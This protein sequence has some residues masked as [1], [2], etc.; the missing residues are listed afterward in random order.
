M[1][2]A[3]HDAYQAYLRD[4][5]NRLRLTDWVVELHRNTAEAGA[6]ASVNVMGTQD[7]AT[8]RLAWPEFFG[9]S[10][11]EQR[12]HLVHELVHCVLHR[13]CDVVEQLAEMWSE[14]AACQFARKAFLR[15]EEIAVEHLA[16]VI[17][18]FLPLP[19]SAGEPV[20]ARRDSGPQDAPDSS[21]GSDVPVPG[22]PSRGGPFPAARAS[23]LE[24]EG[25]DNLSRRDRDL[26]KADFAAALADFAAALRPEAA[27]RLADDLRAAATAAR[28]RQGGQ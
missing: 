28:E 22:L 15:E 6:W 9:E 11:E 8:V 2:D 24:W 5:A 17:A 20:P 25:D 21:R 3:T 14:N 1:N 4:L 7:T 10:P 23:V 12:E 19:P 27:E 26:L 18:P 16:R 13:Q